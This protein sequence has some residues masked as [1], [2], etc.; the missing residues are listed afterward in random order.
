MTLSTHKS[1]IIIDEDPMCY[2]RKM[3]EQIIRVTIRQNSFETIGITDTPRREQKTGSGESE[4]LLV[5]NTRRNV[6]KTK[7]S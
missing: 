4:R 7:K 5:C 3:A 2:S 1:I 6:N